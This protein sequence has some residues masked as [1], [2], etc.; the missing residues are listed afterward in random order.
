MGGVLKIRKIIVKLQIEAQA[1]IGETLWV[2][3]Q[4]KCSSV[5]KTHAVNASV[6][7]MLDCLYPHI[8]WNAYEV[9]KEGI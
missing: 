5:C 7:E 6:L 4:T 3:A 2:S 9:N 1:G 8:Y